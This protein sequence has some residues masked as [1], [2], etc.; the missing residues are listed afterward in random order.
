MD[1]NNITRLTEQLY[2][3]IYPRA[4]IFNRDTDTRRTWES[5][6]DQLR[7]AVIDNVLER[8]RGDGL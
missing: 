1:V 2:R 8:Y 4:D 6:V 5:A 3:N 7:N